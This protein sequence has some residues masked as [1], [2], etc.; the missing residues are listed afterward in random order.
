MVASGSYRQRP[1]VEWKL[2]TVST[3]ICPIGYSPDLCISEDPDW[4]LRYGNL[5]NTSTNRPLDYEHEYNRLATAGWTLC[6]GG[7]VKRAHLIKPTQSAAK[8]PLTDSSG[9]GE[10]L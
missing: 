2:N 10:S 8:S 6:F 1:K 4:S 7:V 3:T 9:S 5:A